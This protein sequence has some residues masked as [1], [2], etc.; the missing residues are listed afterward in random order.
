MH[1]PETWGFVQFAGTNAG[2]LGDFEIPAY[3]YT[4][5]ELRKLYYA[6][7]SYRAK[8]QQY[9]ERLNQLETE[10]PDQAEIIAGLGTYI[11]SLPGLGAVSWYIDEQGHTWSSEK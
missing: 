4:K 3:E 10:I 8:H 9:A 1:R 6:Q 2:E 11:I 7:R 5:W